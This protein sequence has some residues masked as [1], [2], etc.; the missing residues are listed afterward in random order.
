[1]SLCIA[2]SQQIYLSGAAITD[3]QPKMYNGFTLY[4]A[5]CLQNKA[6]K[7]DRQPTV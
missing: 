7:H 6:T 1:M 5:N 2:S 3:E 4:V